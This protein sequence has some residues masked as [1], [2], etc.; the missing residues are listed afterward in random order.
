MVVDDSAYLR[1][2][3]SNTLNGM[4]EVEVVATA[5]NGHEAITMAIRQKPDLI[6]LDLEMPE[7]DGF[8]FLRW[9]MHNHPTSTIIVSSEGREENVLKALD[10]GA[11]DFIVKPTRKISPELESI[12]SLLIEKVNSLRELRIEKVKDRLETTGRHQQQIQP[13][14]NGSR[15]GAIDIVTIG[16]ST[17]GPPAL[18]MILNQLPGN[19]ATPVAVVQHMP[20]RFTRFFAERLNATC[21]LEV[22]EAEEGDEI[23]PG[24]VLIA[25][26][27]KNMG[28]QR[29][30]DGVHITISEDNASRRYVPSVDM[31][32][33]SAAE[34]Y[35]GKTLGVILTGMGNDGAAGVGAIRKAGGKTIAESEKTAII[36]GMPR[37]AVRE[38]GAEK[39]ADVD[40][41]AGF[42]LSICS[43]AEE[44]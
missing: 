35:G 16:A 14:A 25:P 19:F 10:L 31:M 23:R 40:K 24:L 42:L 36:F 3:I 37:E 28:F 20:P 33:E 7:M 5:F 12:Q 30:G 34:V 38:G 2:M 17:G 11:V 21:R 41:I 44:V 32:M 27:G 22:K 13:A 26:G 18:Q 6:T 15:A 9:L 1:R 29:T 43:G 4:P 39:V 8:T